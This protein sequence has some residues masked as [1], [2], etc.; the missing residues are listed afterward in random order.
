VAEAWPDDVD[1]D[2][3]GIRGWSFGGFLA[4]L[5]VL[6]R[7]DVFHAAVAGAPVTEWRLYDTAYTERYLGDPSADPAPYDACSLIPLAAS[8]ARP[9]LIIHGLTDDN[10][11][12]A[13]ALQLSG[14]LTVAGRPH[15]VLPLS[16]VTHM[17]P[18]EEVAENKLLLELDFL[19]QALRA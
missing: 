16:G 9:L 19:R 3:V 15:S 18:Q 17:T 7:P 5:A 12:V 8:L 2:R 14:A 11:V 6:R 1:T 13:H 4:A 10:V